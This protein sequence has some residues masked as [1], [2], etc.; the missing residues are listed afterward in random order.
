L[1]S[2]CLIHLSSDQSHHK[3]R[4]EGV[5]I[6]RVDLLELGGGRGEEEEGRRRKGGGGGEEEEGRR[7]RGG[8]RGEEE[9]EERSLS[10]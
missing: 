3:I 8:G 10:I 4:L 6:H 2:T 9:E 7:K 5:E 1:N